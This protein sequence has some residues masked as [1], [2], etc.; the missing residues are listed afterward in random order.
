MDDELSNKM[1]TFGSA[2]EIKDN[3]TWDMLISAYADEMKAAVSEA[4]SN[5]LQ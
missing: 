3:G 5:A 2:P 1:I 4:A